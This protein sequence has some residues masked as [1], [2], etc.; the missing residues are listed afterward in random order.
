MK[1]LAG[2]YRA[3]RRANPVFYCIVELS[4]CGTLGLALPD[5]LDLI[6]AVLS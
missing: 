6:R 3:E 4:V 2:E 1:M 5:I